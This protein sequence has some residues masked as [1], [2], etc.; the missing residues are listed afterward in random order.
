MKK[1]I[2][3]TQKLHNFLTTLP[4]DGYPPCN[5]RNGRPADGWTYGCYRLTRAIRGTGLP[6]ANYWS[7]SAPTPSTQY[8][9]AIFDAAQNAGLLD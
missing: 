1:I 6:Y 5:R 3:K 2:N 7:G 8:P 9:Q 4:K